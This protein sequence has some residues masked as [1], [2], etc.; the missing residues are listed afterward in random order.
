MVD[1][2][3]NKAELSTLADGTPQMS[4]QWIRDRLGEV[5]GRREALIILDEVYVS[6][7]A[8]VGP[9]G[10]VEYFL[11]DENGDVIRTFAP[12]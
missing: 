4:R 11:L 7:M 1:S 2:K 9:N 3:Y 5:V 10:G 12:P 8:K 6:V